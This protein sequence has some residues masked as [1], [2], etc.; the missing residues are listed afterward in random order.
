[1]TSPGTRLVNVTL[2]VFNEAA[3]LPDG[4]GRLRRFLSENC[5]FALEVVI[6]DNASTDGTLDI[7]RQLSREWE[8]TRVLRLDKKGRGGA[9]KHGWLESQAD[10]LSYMDIDLS[11]DLAAFGPL[12]EALASG[13][14][15]LA[16][17]SRLRPESATA[18]CWR[19]EAISRCY[20]SL[21]KIVFRS[22]FSDAQ[23]GFKAITREAA[24]RLLP[25][26]EDTGWFFDTELLVLAEKC[27]YRIFDLPVRWT[28]DPDSRV[29][30]LRTAWADLRGIL[31]LYRKLRRR[32]YAALALNPAPAK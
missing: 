18:R 19:R 16:V 2:P 26:V 31:C 3:R 10:V 25:A 9:L 17:G 27:G 22:R 1:M 13:R 4:F 12:V 21:V 30:I 5:R 6:V 29:K 8:G 20:I 14:F 32:E 28:E 24:A 7:A 11:T 23:C 15:D